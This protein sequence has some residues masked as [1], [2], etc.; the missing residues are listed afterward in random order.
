MILLIVLKG[1]VLSDQR[2]H[3]LFGVMVVPSTQREV[4]N[5]EE[6]TENVFKPGNSE[7]AFQCDMLLLKLKTLL[8]FTKYESG[9]S[10]PFILILFLDFIL[11][12]ISG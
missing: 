9:S 11:S 5:Y 12:V 8:E 4:T 7:R 2:E 3:F 6:S 1:Q 10:A